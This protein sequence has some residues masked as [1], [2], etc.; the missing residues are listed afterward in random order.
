M[1][2]FIEV[3]N[4]AKAY[5]LV[6]GES[7]NY[8]F[9]GLNMSIKRGSKMAIVGP[10]GSGKS[11]FLQLLSGLDLPSH[12]QVIVDGKNIHEFSEEEAARF[13][14]L[15]F[16]FVF[17][18]HHLL[19]SLTA[20]ENIMIP[21]LAG[22]GELSGNDLKSRAMELLSE[23]GLSNRANHLPGQLSGG[24]CQRVAVARALINKPKLLL[25]DEPTGA[26]DHFHAKSLIDLLHSLNRVHNLTLVMVTHERKFAREM[27]EVWSFES[28]E[29]KQTVL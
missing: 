8:V 10:S 29:L 21:A 27:D 24:E 26:L 6:G 22:H 12:G 4:L 15:G 2:T 20:I 19:P 16:G 28:G 1:K 23:V 17:Q 18:A 14:N 5:P 25:A 9:Y 13:R 11:T 3:R 7:E